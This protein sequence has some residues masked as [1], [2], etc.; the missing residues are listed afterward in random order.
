MS[1]SPSSPDHSEH[2]HSLRPVR[3]T[4]TL[5]VYDDGL[6]DSSEEELRPSRTGKRE[7][8]SF[9]SSSSSSSDTYYEESDRKSLHRRDFD[10][11]SDMPPAKRQARSYERDSSHIDLSA[12]AAAHLLHGAQ[13]ADA[14]FT[15]QGWGSPML[16]FGYTAYGA[17]AV[18][19]FLPHQMSLAHEQAQQLARSTD[20][21]TSAS[22][23]GSQWSDRSSTSRQSISSSSTSLTASTSTL[24][25]SGSSKSRMQSPISSHPQ[26]NMNIGLSG[27]LSP[28]FLPGMGASRL[29][30]LLPNHASDTPPFQQETH[31][32][33]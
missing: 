11:I 21:L 17:P 2:S 1:P 10:D 32:S 7:P 16:G 26:H 27:V 6:S 14:R 28:H 31:V 25:D 20:M 22:S 3:A 30:L 15:P 4:R 13:L 5:A 8:S 24:A 9:S 29:N 18:P 19:Q 12:S 23:R 33:H